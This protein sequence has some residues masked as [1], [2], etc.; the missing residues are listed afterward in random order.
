MEGTIA[1]VPPKGGRKHPQQEY[2][3]V[4]T[5]DILFICGGAFVGLDDVV[6]QRTGKK[7][8]GFGA[9]VKAEAEKNYSELI[10]QVETDDILKFGFIPEFIGRC[11]VLAT[12][13][14]LD[15]KA[16]IEILTR[17]KNAIVKQYQRLF[18][19]EKA[20]LEFT[21]QALEAVA[22]EAVRRKSGARGLRAILEGIMM[23]VMY[24]VPQ[25]GSISEIMVN[26]DVIL[27]G[28]RPSVVHSVEKDKPE[29]E[30]N[31]TEKQDAVA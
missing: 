14:D 10:G 5:T 16:L 8:I 27:K 7:Q 11:P 12:L 18:E 9:D 3:P 28:A 24:E 29:T 6:A 13:D 19:F 26:E 1:R 23:D 22:R 21:P 4:D 30:K 31:E 15:E 2:I 25:H 17:P 20:K